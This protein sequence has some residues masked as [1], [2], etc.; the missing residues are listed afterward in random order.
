[1]RMKTTIARIVRSIL[2]F[3]KSAGRVLHLRDIARRYG[4]GN[5]NIQLGRIMSGA[6]Y[7][8]SRS[9]VLNYDF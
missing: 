1:M 3:Q 5:V 6:E 9:R 2:P 8:A 7:E 4:R